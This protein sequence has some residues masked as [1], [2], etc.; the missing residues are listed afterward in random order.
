MMAGIKRKSR[1]AFRSLRACSMPPHPVSHPFR[2]LYLLS[3]CI[4]TSQLLF[5][6]INDHQLSNRRTLFSSVLQA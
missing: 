2:L 6:P 5:S 3:G 4:S 1:A